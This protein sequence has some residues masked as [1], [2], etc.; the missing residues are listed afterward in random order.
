MS[1]SLADLPQEVQ[2]ILRP[3][4][5]NRTLPGLDAIGV[6]IAKKRDEAKAAR[7]SSG[8]E[9][10]WIA[11]EEAYIGIDDANRHEFVKAMWAK[12][13]S[14]DGPVTTNAS[15]ADN[16]KS[17]AFYRLTA[18]YTDAGAAKVAE[19]L[20]PA[21]AK[22]FEFDATPVPDLVEA[23]K[24]ESQVVHP[25]LGPLTR[26]L[27]EGETAPPGTP[28]GQEPRV[29]LLVK[30]VALEK[31]E[32]ARKRAKAAETRIYD[33]MVES[34]YRREYRRLIK[35]AAKLGTGILKGPFPKTKRN[36]ALTRDAG[37]TNVAIRTKII[38]AC[39]RKSV[40]DIFPD[41]ACGEDIHEGSY[42]FERDTLSPRKVSDLKKLP[43]Y[44]AEQIDKVLKEGPDKV[45]L[46]ESQDPRDRLKRN[47]G[48]FTVWY[49]YGALTRDEMAAIDA[50]VKVKGFD[51]EADEVYAI[52]TL[53]NDSVVRA[54][55]NPLDSGSFPYHSMA[56]QERDGHWAGVGVPEQMQMPQ[57]MVNAANRAM[58][59]NAGKA[60]DNQ[61]V[62]NES[63]I[64]PADDKWTITPGKLWITTDQAPSDVRD[65]FMA[66]PIANTTEMLER[67]ITIAERFAEESTSIPLIT[68]GQSGPS[69][70]DTYGA[71]QLQNNNANQLLRSIGYAFDD[72]I[73]EPV[74]HQYYEWLLMD[75]DVPDEEK[76]DYDIDAHGSAALVERAIQAQFLSQALSASLNPA[77]GL[78][79]KKAMAEN[80]KAQK[81]DPKALQYTEEEQAKLDA[82]PPPAPPQIE[83]AKINADTQLK[84]GVMKQGTDQQTI[85]HEKQIADAAN[86]LEGASVHVDATVALHEMQMKRQLAELEYANKQGI[87]LA[88]VKAQLAQTAMRLQTETHLNAVN[89]AIDVGKHR[90][91][92]A[93]ELHKHRN[94][95]P[96]P[97]V[98]VPGRAGRGKAFSQAPA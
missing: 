8:I 98:Q 71:A 48:R 32:T 33:W 49:F 45:N 65:A 52:V 41:P 80:L 28:E 29:P 21:D 3:H 61:Y 47:K 89:N 90:V 44:M 84:L 26:P 79:P 54:T 40:W 73:T 38:P 7:T 81:L 88:E 23:S 63:A 56:W 30:D 97:P 43:G 2:E 37:G 76:G 58:L 25:E 11:A 18:R 6:E 9:D 20:L 60:A 75:P 91:D 83:V 50:V 87:S 14:P 70:P 35:D 69:T 42:I 12:P 85:Q 92:K 34:G 78:D 51:R 10:V 95:S 96:K 82:A 59:N 53:I 27:K 16:T 39:E 57:R 86:E 93:L 4:M 74:V 36:A 17:T 94:P 15:P 77:F 24:D 1:D 5:E 68:Q 62:I 13:M 66:I 67:I 19:I 72:Y 22:A 46:D 64:V 31:I 55:V